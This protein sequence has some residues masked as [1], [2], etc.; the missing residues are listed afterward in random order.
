MKYRVALALLS[1]AV[2]AACSL[3]PVDKGASSSDEGGSS[4]EI[5]PSADPPDSSWAL[6]QSP[7]CDN[8]N[9]TIPLETDFPPIYLPDGGT[10]TNPCDEIESES[11]QIRTTNCAGCHSPPL[12]LGQWNWVLNDNMLETTKY[13]G[14]GAPLVIAGDPE[15]SVLYQKVSQ[16]LDTTIGDTDYTNG[17]PPGGTSPRPSVA[18]VSVLYQW[19]MCLDTDGGPP[20]F[21]NYGAEGGVVV[22]DDGGAPDTG[23]G[24]ADSGAPDTGTGVV[25]SGGGA[26]DT[27]VADT[28]VP[29]T[30]IADTGVAET[31]TP[32]PPPVNLITNGNFTDATTDWGV[33]DGTATISIV[34]GDLCVAVTAANEATTVVL[35]WPEPEGTAGVPLSAAGSYTFSFTAHTTTRTA[36]TVDATVGDTVAPYLPVD[37]QSAGDRVTNTAATFA[38]T[39]TPA[40]GADS[41]AG[42]SFSFVS[43]VAQSLCFANVSLVEN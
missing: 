3:Q 22:D 28:G 18:D 42:V 41:S 11:M 29:D 36:I 9:G 35:G 20:A 32:P 26:P 6:C 10:T 13:V 14:T 30:G 15:D 33:V 12:D 37:F 39:F 27:G 23:V 5:A 7:E 1:S 21:V 25:D 38:H 17:M 43:G 8:T 2:M 31:G 24:V 40:S 4:S 16:G 19:I 34:G